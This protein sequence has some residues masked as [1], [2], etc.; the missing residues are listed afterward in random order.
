MFLLYLM[1]ELDESIATDGMSYV[2]G[3]LCNFILVFVLPFSIA[4][5]VVLMLDSVILC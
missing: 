4:M 5:V 3:V 1:M 2:L